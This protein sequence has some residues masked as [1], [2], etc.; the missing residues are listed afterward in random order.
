MTL[1][2]DTQHDAP[3]TDA[4]AAQVE[5]ADCVVLTAPHWF[6]R[7]DFLAWLT[8]PSRVAT[9]RREGDKT[10]EYS[11]AFVTFDGG[12]DP[13]PAGE[14]YEGCDFYGAGE[15]ALPEDIERE[16]K[17]ALATCRATR[18]VVWIRPS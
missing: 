11:D 1:P 4:P 7:A 13:G 8:G 12:S 15:Y 16:I 18:G 14:R 6:E 9:W 5:T 10:T 2:D 17:A 3:A